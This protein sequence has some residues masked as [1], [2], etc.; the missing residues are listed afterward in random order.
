M[1]A[2]GAGGQHQN[3]TESAVRAVHVPTGLSAVARNERSQ[4]RNRAAALERLAE[5]VAASVDPQRRAAMRE[6]WLGRITVERGGPIRTY[7]EGG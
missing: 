2:G 5:L 1:R 4:H 6:A 3:K 7:R